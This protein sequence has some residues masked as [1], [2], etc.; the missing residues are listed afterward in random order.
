MPLVVVCGKPCVGKTSFSNQLYSYFQS[1]SLTVY[2]INEESAKINK[3]RGY[4]NSFSEKS[5]RAT[6]KSQVNSKLSKDSYVILDSLNYIKGESLRKIETAVTKFIIIYTLHNFILHWKCIIGY[7]YELYC[8]SRAIQ[9][10]YCVCWIECPN[11][12][13]AIEWNSERLNNT[14]D[15]YDPN[16]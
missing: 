9:T 2:L 5:A 10:S 11:S 13:T 3:L 1:K 16:M 14:S 6:L 4:H 8:I 7:R 12:T 15:G